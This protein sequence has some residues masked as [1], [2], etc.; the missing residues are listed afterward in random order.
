MKRSFLLPFLCFLSSSLFSAGPVTHAYLAERFLHLHPEYREETVYSF[1]RGTL[2][3][4][5]RSMAAI[6]REKTHALGVKL[7]EVYGSKTA[8]QAGFLF[9]SFVDEKREKFIKKKNFYREVQQHFSLPKKELGTFLKLAE[10]EIFFSRIERAPISRALLSVAKEESILQIPHATI[11]RWHNYLLLCVNHRP[12]AIM[13]EL[14]QENNGFLHYTP[15]T[16]A[17]WSKKL[18]EARDWTPLQKYV[19][20]LVTHFDDLHE[21]IKK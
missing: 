13:K 18:Q 17:R 6:P 9:H 12:H 14:A 1:M 16:V 8:F 5:I 11:V 2:F 3:P 15:E 20:E 21:S 10:D 7:K 19:D 4:D